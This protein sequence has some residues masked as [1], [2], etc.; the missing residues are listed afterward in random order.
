MDKKEFVR[1]ISEYNMEMAIAINEDDYD[2]IER[3]SI[4]IGK[5]IVRYLNDR[6]LYV[7]K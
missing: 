7:N 4:R 3:L 1:K 2:E 5:L 6:K